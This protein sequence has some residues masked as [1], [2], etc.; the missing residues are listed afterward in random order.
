ML[1]ELAPAGSPRPW[2]PLA[3]TLMLHGALLAALLFNWRWDRAAPVPTALPRFVEAELLELSELKAKPA[4]RRAIEA[5]KAAPAP[6][7]KA[8][9]KAAPK[10]KPPPETAKAEAKAAPK[11]PTAGALEAREELAIALAAEDELLLAA[12]DERLAASYVAL[13][14]RMIS[15]RWTRPLN[16]RNDM[17]TELIIQLIPTGEVVSVAVVRSSGLPAF[18]RSAVM[19]VRKAERFPELQNLPPR[20][21]EQN[22]RKL[23]LKFKPEDLRF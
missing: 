1:R 5:P 2:Q 23:R 6:A 3:G 7:E 13:I 4:P 18:D 10:P 20:V 19:A 17:E 11:R 14:S 12:E 16:A 9:E 21:F 15:E 8:P 22:F